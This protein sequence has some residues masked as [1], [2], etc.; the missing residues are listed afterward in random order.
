MS[1]LLHQHCTSDLLCCNCLSLP[2]GVGK[3]IDSIASKPKGSFLSASVLSSA[4]Q[5]CSYDLQ[6]LEGVGW[7]MLS[8]IPEGL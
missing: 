1:L 5:A 3:C 8:G 6:G 2:L 7:N 4:N